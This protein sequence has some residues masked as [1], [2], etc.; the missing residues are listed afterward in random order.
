MKIGFP[1]PELPC[2]LARARAHTHTH[3][4]TNDDP[5]NTLVPLKAK[6]SLKFELAC[7]NSPF[8][9]LVAPHRWVIGDRRVGI[10]YWSHLLESEC[11]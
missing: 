5:R 7:L 3:T 10:V 11:P 4:H 8:F 2:G 6:N 1:V 9:R